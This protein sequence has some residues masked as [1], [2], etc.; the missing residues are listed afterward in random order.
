MGIGNWRA[1]YINFLSKSKRETELVRH[2]T[3]EGGRGQERGKGMQ[4]VGHSR[5]WRRRE[6]KDGEKGLVCSVMYF[7]PL[8]LS[9]KLN[10]WLFYVTSGSLLKFEGKLSLC[11]G[12]KMRI[13]PLNLA[14][15]LNWRC[16]HMTWGCEVWPRDVNILTKFSGGRT[17]ERTDRWSYIWG[18]GGSAQ[19]DVRI[20]NEINN[21]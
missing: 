2:I 7:T 10:C 21:V 18:F 6:E 19:N 9:K 17:D 20:K 14:G 13:S 8:N 11:L 12:H 5:K 1:I 3:R 15:N 16:G 4:M